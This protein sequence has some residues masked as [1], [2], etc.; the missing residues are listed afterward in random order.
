[1]YYYEDYHLLILPGNLLSSPVLHTGTPISICPNT[2]ADVIFKP[3]DA[4]SLDVIPPF[5]IKNDG[6]IC[7]YLIIVVNE[8][9]ICL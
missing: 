6:L 4:T 2:I 8:S 7:K 9:E 1:M 5:A 3:F